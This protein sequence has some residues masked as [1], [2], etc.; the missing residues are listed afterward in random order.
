MSQTKA[1]APT[2]SFL[3]WALS[4]LLLGLKFIRD[5]LF[6][7]MLSSI[8]RRVFVEGVGFRG[9]DHGFRDLGGCQGCL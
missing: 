9:L 8:I 6:W 3:A 5:C 2:A 4:Q 1:K 7:G